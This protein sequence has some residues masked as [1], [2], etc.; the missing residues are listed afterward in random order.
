M[1]DTS[2]ADPAERLAR[3]LAEHD[4]VAGDRIVSQANPPLMTSVGLL[5]IVG[6]HGSGPAWHLYRERAEAI[7][8]FLARPEDD[9]IVAAMATA[10]KQLLRVEQAMRKA[11][12]DPDAA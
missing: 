10:T 6:S 7:L 11:G 3:F 9:E 5:H 4:G 1:T 2:S 8:R 12:L